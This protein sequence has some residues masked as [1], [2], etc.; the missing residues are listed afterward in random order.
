MLSSSTFMMQ[1]KFFL[2]KGSQL[3]LSM[4]RITV[5]V[6]YRIKK[7]TELDQHDYLFDLEGLVAGLT[8]SF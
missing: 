6:G 1:P 7:Y 4:Q 5:T 8:Y 3:F 2:M